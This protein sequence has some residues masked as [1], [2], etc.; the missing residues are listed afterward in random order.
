MPLIIPANTLSG[1]Y[2]VANSCR[3]N[4]PDSAYMS[5]TQ[6]SGNRRKATFST[7]IKGQHA[8][9]AEQMIMSSGGN[10]NIYTDSGS[11]RINT[12]TGDY[13]YSTALYRDPSAWYHFCVAI[14]TEQG[15]AANRIKIYVNGTQVTVFSASGDPS[16]DEDLNM[17]L[18]GETFYISKSAGS[19]YG[20]YYL[21]ETVW[22]DGLQ[23]APTSFG[24]FDEDSPTIWKP[25]DVSGLT[26]GTNGFY[27]DFEA[28]DNLGNDANGGTDLTEV[29]LAATDQSLDSPTNNFAVPNILLDGIDMSYGENNLEIV[30]GTDA[31]YGTQ[32]SIGMTAGKWYM[33]LK[34]TAN[35]SA[36]NDR[37]MV[38][39]VGNPAHL[40]TCGI[41]PSINIASGYI[42]SN[43][44]PTSYGYYSDSGTSYNND[45]SSSYGDTWTL[46]DIIG[47]YLDC[48]NNK[49]YFSKNGTVQ[50]SGTGISI[51]APAS[52]AA[53]AY[54]FGF[55]D[56]SSYGGTVQVNFGGAS[57]YSNSSSVSD[58]NGFGSFEYSPSGTFDGASKD[59]LALCTK[60]LG[61]DGG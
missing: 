61:S 21:A 60:N 11:L 28:S 54:F 31:Q 10:M 34:H 26:F 57:C 41:S 46:N 22:I 15:V 27:L 7:W 1:G 2:E 55:S 59:F 56:T 25:I 33:E 16:E 24:E 9:Y 29:N 36:G 45:V 23:L 30:I 48:D 47:I 39:I 32:S 50:N 18:T 51:T 12:G 3:F 5:K 14:D 42:G 40:A 58:A 17:N 8:G 4:R 38:G 35:T 43:S 6:G 49:L 53:G 20:D 44:E 52:T 37:V 19:S 13:A